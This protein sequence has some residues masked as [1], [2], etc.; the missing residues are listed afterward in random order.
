MIHWLQH[1]AYDAHIRLLLASNPATL[2]KRINRLDWYQAALHEWVHGLHCTSAGRLLEVGCA[3]GALSEYLAEHGYSV[4][5][6][7]AS[8]KM[9]AV[10]KSTKHRAD[11]RLANA[12]A[13]PFADNEFDAIVSSSLINIVPDRRQAIAEMVRACKP[14]GLISIHVP[15]QGFSNQQFDELA[16]SLR[17]SAFS[18]A[19]LRAWHKFAPKL[20]KRELAA[21]FHDAGLTLTSINDH[22][23]GML[24]SMT[25][26][27]NA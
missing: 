3:T 20:D 11:Y 26:A 15:T 25:G 13:L 8:A 16:I 9:I 14:G 18:A 6:V 4:V 27:K 22:L 17:V 19:A 21:L 1:A 5:A 12:N 2:F 24:F 10:A 23:Q 7:D